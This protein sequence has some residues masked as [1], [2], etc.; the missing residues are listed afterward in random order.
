VTEVFGPAYAAAYDAL[1]RDKDYAGEAHWLAAVFERY[2]DASVR[3]VLDMGCG[4]GSHALAL[5]VLGFRMTGVDRSAAMLELAGSKVASGAY[6]IEWL[7]SDLRELAVGG[8]FDAAVMM[9]NVLGYLTGED[10]PGAVLNAARRALR[11]GGLLVFDAWYGPAVLRQRPEP[12][13]KRVGTAAGELVRVAEP[14]LD[15]PAQTCTVAYRLRD[16]AGRIVTEEH[17]IRFFFA[18]ELQRLLAG[19]G[20][21][22]LRLGQWP[23]LERDPDEESWSVAVVARAP[24]EAPAASR[25]GVGP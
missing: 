5:A 8:E 7:R 6:G 25:A 1:Y 21:E 22:L 15:V 19:A 20:F 17:R 4:T 3:R 24:A 10:E 9:F 12:R 13:T 11:P 2:G 14:R 23:E 16:A 18:G